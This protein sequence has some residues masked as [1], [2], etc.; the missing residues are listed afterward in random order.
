MKKKIIKIIFIIIILILLFFNFNKLNAK[1]NTEK[2]P[3][4]I[5]E[6]KE[7]NILL[8]HPITTSVNVI[9]AIIYIIQLIKSMINKNISNKKYII[10][11]ITMCLFILS[12]YIVISYNDYIKWYFN[13][14]TNAEYRKNSMFCNNISV[15]IIRVIINITY[16]IGMK[17]LI[18]SNQK[19]K[20]G[21]KNEKEN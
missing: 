13:L 20:F 5:I 1:I 6:Q 21:V 12:V 3:F 19:I 10:L 7:T 8:E 15:F 17:K 16:I 14:N 4:D 11:A 18:K 9:L 2:I